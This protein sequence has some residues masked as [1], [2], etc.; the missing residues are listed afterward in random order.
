MKNL[1]PTLICLFL[2][3][4]LQAG[5]IYV[6]ANAT[7]DMNGVNWANAYN[8]LQDALADANSNVDV[9][10]IWVAEGT[11]KPVGP[12]GSRTATFQLIS[13]VSIMGDFKPVGALGSSV[14]QTPT[15]PSSAET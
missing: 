1:I 10:D 9:N 2:V 3:V 5:I 12:G 7:G 13:G 11:Y 4:P 15:K 6:D 14:T 8:Y